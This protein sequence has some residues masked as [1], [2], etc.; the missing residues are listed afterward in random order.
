MKTTFQIL[1]IKEIPFDINRDINITKEIMDNIKLSFIFVLQY[2]K[3]TD[4]IGLHTVVRYSIPDQK[5]L[6]E[7]GITHIAQL[8]DWEEI[9]DSIMY[10]GLR[11]KFH[12]PTLQKKLLA[13]GEEEL[14]EG[15]WWNDTYWGV[16]NGVGQNNLG[17]ILMEVRDEIRRQNS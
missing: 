12:N 7:G 1:R 8:S 15:N 9:K 10:L 14:I 2:Q 13:T 11:Q 3:T 6:L 17:K 4:I 16:C 5:P